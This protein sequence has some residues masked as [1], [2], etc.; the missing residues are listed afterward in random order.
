[1]KTIKHIG[2]DIAHALQGLCRLPSWWAQRLHKRDSYLWTFGA[3]D[4]TRY[5]DNSR[6]LF[7]YVV[8][9]CP[10]IR[11]VWMTHSIEIVE[12]LKNKG[13]PVAL[14][15]S[16]EGT[17]I[18]RNAGFFFA[19]KGAND[20]SAY[21]LNGI[22]YINLWHG[23]PLKQIGNDAQLFIRKNT[24]FKR[25]KT[26]CRRFLVPW[27]FMKGPTLS[28]SPFF[29][30][31]LLSAFELPT[32]DV[33]ETGLPRIDKFKSTAPETLIQSLDE[34]FNHPLKVLYMP[35]F[36]D[37]EWGTFNPFLH[38]GFD[39]AEFNT[40]LEKHNIVFLYK[41]HYVDSNVKEES[42]SR[43]FITISDNDYDDLYTF[44]RDVDVLI[45][46]YSSI[47]FDFLY[48][49][50]PIILLPFDEEAYVT[51][52]RPFYFDYALLEAKK[53]YSWQEL[54]QCLATRD[55]HVPS[56]EEVERF[57][58]IDNG[59]THCEQIVEHIFSMISKQNSSSSKNT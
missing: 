51:Q 11:A 22:H 54:M 33:W 9:K 39:S 29:T 14:C 52:S 26:A 50:K 27:E 8:A 38:T 6:A 12:Q 19:T 31:F 3:W 58:G 5:S 59:K 13:L 35:T 42:S 16:E 21:N 53:V 47:Y 34:R 24:L 20:T 43:R 40:L 55:Y 41:G 17:R 1:M 49:R 32:A 18:Q 45:T 2:A 56:D 15:E 36:R 7:E 57:C 4:G 10:Q 30:P 46:D 44:V 48:L 28:S 25:F 23:M 37:K